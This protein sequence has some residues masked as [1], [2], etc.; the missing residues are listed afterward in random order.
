MKLTQK[1][2]FKVI[3]IVTRTT[4][5]NMQAAQDIPLLWKRF[6]EENIASKIPN[7]VDDTV[8]AIYTN[9]ESDYTKAYDMVLGCKVNEYNEIPE[10]MVVL[11][12]PA[13]NYSTFLAK[14]KL[15]ANIVYEKWLEIWNTDLHRKYTADFE[16]Y[17][18]KS[19]NPEEAEVEI[20][21]AI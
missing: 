2:S 3:G 12:I 7:K 15:Q 14:G 17:G 18:E 11:E 1:E 13:S 9:Y 16:V 10:G 19:N 5:E 20:H 4:N 6:M 21:I 8:Y